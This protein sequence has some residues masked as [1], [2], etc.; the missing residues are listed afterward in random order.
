M[1]SGGHFLFAANQ[2]SNSIS[3]YSIDA[4]KGTLTEIQGSPFSTGF[5]SNP[6]ALAITPA[7]KFLYVAAPNLQSIFSYSVTSGALQPVP[8]SPVLVDV[9]PVSL[10]V[11]PAGHFLYV[12]NFIGNTL[13]VLAID[14][15]SGALTAIPGSPFSVCTST[16]T[17]CIASPVW[18]AINPSGNVLYT[19][20]KGTNNVSVF[21][22]ASSTGVPTQIT[23]SPFA[24]GTAP[25]FVSVDS[26]GHFLYVGNQTSKNIT[27]FSIN[28]SA[29]TL[30]TGI[31]GAST[32]TAPTSM[33]TTK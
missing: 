2:A 13:S 31:V 27:E 28:Q 9:G 14:P 26:T 30:P 10:V 5:N 32:T 6:V 22:I 24:T 7:G 20:N 4:A 15:N 23:N 29:G 19:A 8:N 18:V 11:D 1:D 3:V 33:V 25:V 12:A 16:T 17:T 21:S